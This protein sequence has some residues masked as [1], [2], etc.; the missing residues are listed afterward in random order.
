[1][2]DSTLYRFVLYHEKPMFRNNY[3]IVLGVNFANAQKT[4]FDYCNNNKLWVAF[5]DGNE[6]GVLTKTGIDY[7]LG[8]CNPD[9]ELVKKLKEQ[10]I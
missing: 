7:A 1:M 4:R 6:I 10:N 9:G 5:E 3:N 2:D 8:L